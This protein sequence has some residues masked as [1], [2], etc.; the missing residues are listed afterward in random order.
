[1]YMSL[2]ISTPLF[3]AEW[4]RQR[5][6][7]WLQKLMLLILGGIWIANPAAA[8]TPAGIQATIEVAGDLPGPASCGS[9]HK[10]VMIGIRTSDV[11]ETIRCGYVVLDGERLNVRVTGSS[12]HFP[13]GF[14]GIFPQ[15][16]NVI[17]S[18][19]SF[20]SFNRMRVT[21]SE[22]L[23]DGRPLNVRGDTRYY[24]PPE[25][26][27]W[28][29]CPENMA[30]LGFR[31]NRILCA[32]LWSSNTTGAGAGTVNLRHYESHKP[33]T[34]HRP[35]GASGEPWTYH[36]VARG[37]PCFA[38]AADR[39]ELQNM[40]SAT[41]ILLTEDPGCTKDGDFWAELRTTSK[42]VTFSYMP[43]DDI[44]AYGDG[45]II[46]PGLQLVASKAPTT[47]PAGRQLDCVRI[48]TSSAPPGS[49]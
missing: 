20:G 13:T 22:V 33:C 6:A 16:N 24:S 45:S 40:P 36:L 29:Q 2:R 42:S 31:G 25:S 49:P 38:S 48:T 46:R 14:L 7:S 11:L 47:N 18:A 10:G 32:T 12:G 8:A 19:Y 23:A 27:G 17:D 34:L 37:S 41:R 28:V 44:F 35:N 3:L 30:I 21:F 1:M 9:M 43:I 5:R 26:G 15:L 4:I 39:F